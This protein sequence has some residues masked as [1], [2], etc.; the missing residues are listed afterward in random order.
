V[1]A[2]GARNCAALSAKLATAVGVRFDELALT[3]YMF[4][5]AMVGPTSAI[6]KG[7][8]PP[9][10]LCVLRVQLESLCLGYLERQASPL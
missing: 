3:S 5:A 8:A 10:M 1:K 9:K 2:I 4:C 6:F 7:D